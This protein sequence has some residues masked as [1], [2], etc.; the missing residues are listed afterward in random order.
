MYNCMLRKTK[1]TPILFVQLPSPCVDYFIADCVSLVLLVAVKNRLVRTD[2]VH[3]GP[4]ARSVD[5]QPPNKKNK[6][7]RKQQKKY[8]SH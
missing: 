8:S 1:Y 5:H 7:Y 2:P 3:L 4:A 6:H